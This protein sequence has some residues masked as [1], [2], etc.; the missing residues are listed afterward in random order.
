MSVCLWTVCRGTSLGLGHSHGHY[1]QYRARYTNCTYIDGNLELVFLTNAS[2]D[3]SFLQHIREVT[4]YVL[5][6]ACYMDYIPLNNLRVI[7]GR[8]LYEHNGDY[9]SLYVAL[10]YDEH[11]RGV[12]LKELRLTSLHGQYTSTH[13]TTVH[14][15]VAG[16]VVVRASDSRFP[17]KF[18]T[19]PVHCRI[20]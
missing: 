8:T 9:Y 20:A 7:R 5:I 14:L 15:Q 18:V 16:D 13:H 11:T 19:R 17:R 1:N 2:Y 6:V 3:M 4:G 12:G 10:N